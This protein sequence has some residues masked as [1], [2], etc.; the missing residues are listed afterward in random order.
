MNQNG[1]NLATLGSTPVK[2]TKKTLGACLRDPRDCEADGVRVEALGW[3]HSGKAP[4]KER[5]PKDR[6]ETRPRQAARET[7]ATEK[8]AKVTRRKL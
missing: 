2:L 3:K 1:R 5:E 4:R 8:E 7:R 6:Q